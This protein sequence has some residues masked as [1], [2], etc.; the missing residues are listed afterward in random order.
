[1]AIIY[2]ASGCFWGREYHLRKLPG[3]I[4]TRTGFMGGTVAYP[5]YQ[6]V[7]TKVTSHAETVEVMY[8]PAVLP[9][10]TVLTEFF[11]LHDFTIDRSENSGQYRSAIFLT[12]EE[13]LAPEQEEIAL[14]M[15]AKL[16]ANGFSPTTQL[17]KDSIFYPADKRHQQYCSSK[18]MVPKKR[19]AEEIRKILTL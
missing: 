19:G 10:Q 5:T 12:P 2:L 4:S 14:K 6:Q 7:C 1:M 15:L 11:T 18:G 17:R 13:K 3:V 9:T 8:D 16:R